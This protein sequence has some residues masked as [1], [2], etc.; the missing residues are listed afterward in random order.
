MNVVHSR[1][2]GN[3]ARFH[4]TVGTFLEPNDRHNPRC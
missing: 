1:V 2:L 3:S 4:A